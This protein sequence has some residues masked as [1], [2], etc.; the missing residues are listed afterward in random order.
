MSRGQYKRWVAR[1][2]S[3]AGA[4]AFAALL[5]PLRAN[6]PPAEAADPDELTE[7]IIRAPEPR[8]VAPTLRDRIGRVWVPVY[9]NEK[10]PFRLVLDSGAT[11]SAVI[12]RVAQQLG[13][14]TEDSPKVLMRGVTGAAVTP[15][16][17]VA[18]M[19]VGDLEVGRT[20]L[21]LVADAFGGAEGLLG[22]EGMAD[23]RIYID[24]RNDFVNISRSRNRRAETGFHTLP[25]IAGAGKLLMVRANVANVRARAIIDTGAQASIGNLALHEAL[26]RNRQREGTR[27]AITGATGDTQYGEGLSIRS[28]VIGGLIVQ[29]AHITFGDMHIFSHWDASEEPTI[30]IGM[31]VIGLLDTLV[32]D[33]HRREVHIKPRSR[34]FERLPRAAG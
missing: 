26:E 20:T 3:W 8:Y 4:L 14:S 33:Y 23:K 21:P 16:V 9:I 5:Q 19:V 27:D 15:T 13:L 2:S 34:S 17:R 28:I 11:N 10:G 6:T 22:T 29:N 18:S 7:I 31:D 32:I 12:P 1:A 24:F 30:L 25:L